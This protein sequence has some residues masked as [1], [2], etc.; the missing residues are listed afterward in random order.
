MADSFDVAEAEAMEFP[1]GFL[2]GGCV[3]TCCEGATGIA[4]N[5][6]LVTARQTRPSTGA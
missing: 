2:A 5:Q 4:E 1:A 3:I 6:G